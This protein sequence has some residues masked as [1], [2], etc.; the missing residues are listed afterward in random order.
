MYIPEKYD[1]NDF[2][3]HLELINMH[4]LGAIISTDSS[5]EIYVTHIPFAFHKDEQDGKNYLISHLAAKNPHSAQL[6][7]AESCLII[8]QGTNSYISPA[9]YPAKK[10]THK[11]V[12]TWDF[13]VVHVHGKPTILKDDEAKSFALDHISDTQEAKRPEGEQFEP[14]WKVSDAPD[15]YLN[16]MKKAIVALKVEITETEGKWKLE[17]KTQ[18]RNIAG[19]IKGLELEGGENEKKMAA[20]IYDANCNIL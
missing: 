16:I 13:A 1:N 17:Q 11:F 19:T 10:E 7:N 4:P 6:K 20:M 9:W 2:S 14:K 3:Q 12:P 15:S 18:P 8:F 5:G